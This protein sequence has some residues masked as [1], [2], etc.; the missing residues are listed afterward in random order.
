MR[1]RK[2]EM[3]S[4]PRFICGL[5]M[6]LGGD[7]RTAQVAPGIEVA[8]AW[9]RLCCGTWEPVVSNATVASG[10]DPP[11]RPRENPKQPKLRGLEYRCEAR[12]GLP[13]GSEEAW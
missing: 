8:R 5:G 4:K 3:A 7:L 12:G 11:N 6:N 13:G 10:N 1:C 9:L 2:L